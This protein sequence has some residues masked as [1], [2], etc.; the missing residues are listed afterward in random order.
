MP[1]FD[2]E[3]SIKICVPRKSISKILKMKHDSKNC[4]SLWL[5][6]EHFKALEVSL[7]T[8]IDGCEDVNRR[9]LDMLIKERSR[10]EEAWGSIWVGNINKKYVIHL[11]SI[12][13][14]KLRWQGMVTMALQYG[15][16]IYQGELISLLQSKRIQCQMS[17]IAYPATC[18]I[19]VE[20]QMILS[21]TRSP[22]S[23]QGFWYHDESFCNQVK[24][25]E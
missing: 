19:C 2:R 15:P 20:F 3:K 7:D 5:L 11:Q 24:Y 14:L 16:T 18:L 10:W 23:C 4:R 8:K 21:Q 22:V 9:L 1:L 6:K 17:L 13:M 12:S 25:V